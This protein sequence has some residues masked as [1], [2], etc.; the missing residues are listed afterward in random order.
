M[1]TSLARRALP[2]HL[3]P[4]ARQHPGRAPARR[5]DRR[6]LRG[7]PRRLPVREERHRQ[8]RHRRPRVDAARASASTPG[9]TSAVSPPPAC[10]W[11]NNWADPARPAPSAPSPTRSDPH[12]LWTTASPPNSRNSAVPSRSSPTTSSRRR[13]ATSTSGTS[14][15]TRSCARWA[16][17][18]C[19]G[20][21]SRRSTAAW[22]ATTSRSAS[23]WRSWP[24]STPRWRSP[25]RRAS[26]SAR[27]RSTSSAPRSRR[28]SGCPRLCSGEI[29]GAFG[30]TEPDG[31]SDAGATRTTARLDA[32]T[33]E[34]VINGTKCFITNSGTDITG[35][36]T[37]TAVTGRKPTTA[38]RD[39]LDHR[40][41]RHPRLHGRRPVLQGR[42]ERLGHPGAVLRRR[43]R[44]G[45]EPARRARAA[46]TPSSC[47]SSTRAAS[48]SPPSR[49]AWPR[50]AWT[51]R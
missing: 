18:A 1:P 39:L 45:R 24:A 19:S 29:L 10:G 17:W 32:A 36:V 50:A 33:D 5:H 16:A 35:L 46:A 38:S 40:A 44:P 9:S 37:V 3:R 21:R 22:A 12:V 7:R 20:C 48:R 14:S 30:L 13:S 51:S 8:P 15:R 4:G 47:A 26:R 43:P 23:R 27:C 28:R 41:V 42:L 49:P 31:G 11:P 2:R 34:W 25:W 6:R